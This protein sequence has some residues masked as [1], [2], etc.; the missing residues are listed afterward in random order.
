MTY[1]IKEVADK[2][3]LT[4]HTLRFYDKEGLLPSI[5]R[6][7]SGIRRFDDN[8]LEWLG[9][10]CCLKNTGMQIKEIKQFLDWCM[11][12]KDSLPKCVDLLCEHRRHVENQMA[13]LQKNLEK[14]DWKINYYSNLCKHE[15]EGKGA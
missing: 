14:I 12:G 4:P 10:V 13:E 3:G 7:E 11:E 2:F 8:D 1:S 15:V 9:L 5:K 6:T